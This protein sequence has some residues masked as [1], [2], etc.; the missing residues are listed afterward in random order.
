M[1]I[2]ASKAELEQSHDKP[3]ERLEL[4]AGGYLATLGI[5]HELHCLVS[6]RT[7]FITRSNV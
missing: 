6:T 7:W 3:T 1:Y 5:Y 4:V 2:S